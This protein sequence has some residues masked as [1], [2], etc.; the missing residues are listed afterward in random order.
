MY[1]ASD[2]EK[3]WFLYKT[4]G[5]PKGMSINSFCLQ[6]GVPYNEFDKWFKKTHRSVAPVEVTG[7][8]EV[9]TPTDGNI[10]ESPL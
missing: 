9:E 2:F 7:I 4:E 5:E 10:I 8:P 3:L 6:R 1:S